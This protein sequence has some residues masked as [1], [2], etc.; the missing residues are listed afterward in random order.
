MTDCPKNRCLRVLHIEDDPL[1]A[2]IVQIKMLRLPVPCEVTRAETKEAFEAAFEQ[3]AF[4][5]VISDSQV[6]DLDTYSALAR[7]REKYPGV[8]FIFLS[9]NRR[10]NAK[11][12]ALK[13]G[14]TD[15]VNK[16]NLV[17][18]IPAI[19]RACPQAASS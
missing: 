18:L 8:P 13:R 17:E 15:Y 12:D 1:I 7:V 3:G 19:Q 9:A 11:E 5:L 4:D 10:P 16:G 2:E 14:A 6:P